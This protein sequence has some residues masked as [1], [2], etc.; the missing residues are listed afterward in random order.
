MLNIAGNIVSRTTATVS[1]TVS[2][3]ASAASGTLKRGFQIGR[4][5]RQ[6]ENGTMED[7]VIANARDK[8]T[9]NLKVRF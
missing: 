8:A 3:A 7:Y 4:D 2:S 5:R 1:G 9:I 6:S